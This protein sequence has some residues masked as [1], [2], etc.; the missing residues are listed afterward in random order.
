MSAKLSHLHTTK[1]L[2][3]GSSQVCFCWDVEL[4]TGG[5]TGVAGCCAHAEGR[6]WSVCVH[7]LQQQV[8][9]G[10]R[11]E[12]LRGGTRL[13]VCAVSCLQGLCVVLLD[14]YLDLD[15]DRPLR[16]GVLTASPLAQH[17]HVVGRHQAAG[18]AVHAGQ[19]PASHPGLVL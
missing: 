1:G 16:L 6:S 2:G 5:P 18:L 3:A 19:Q 9:G 10:G 4:R 13:S 15:L 8:S 7:R 11:A 12:A 17:L 14:L